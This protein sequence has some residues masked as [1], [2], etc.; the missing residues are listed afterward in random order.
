MRI[1]FAAGL[2]LGCAGL[3]GAQSG[4]LVDPT[5]PPQVAVELAGAAERRPAGPQL[6]SVLISPTRRIAVISG[7]AVPLGGTYGDA[8]VAS[9]SEATVVL[10]YRNRRQ[11]TLHL[12]PEA[13]KRPRDSGGAAH[14]GGT[15][16]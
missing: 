11:Q 12:V 4:E 2:V 10:K 15:A 8:T 9:I 6:Q 14:Q 16:R 7:S 5:R 13:Q 1:A 3:A